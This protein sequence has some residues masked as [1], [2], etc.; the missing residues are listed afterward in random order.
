M[1]TTMMRKLLKKNNLVDERCC[2]KVRDHLVPIYNLIL[3]LN[4]TDIDEI[5]MHTVK[6]LSIISNEAIENLLDIIRIEEKNG[7]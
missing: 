5:D 6:R 7:R 1:K 3:Y 4:D 2:E